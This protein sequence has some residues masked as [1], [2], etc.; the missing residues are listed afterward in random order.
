MSTLMIEDTKDNLTIS[1]NGG[2][3]DNEVR[4]SCDELVEYVVAASMKL[5]V[6]AMVQVTRC[7]TAQ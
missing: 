6:A 5:E 7:D 1:C 4:L 2:K 3:G